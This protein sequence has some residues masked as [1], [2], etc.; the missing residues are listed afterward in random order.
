M[1]CETLSF[2]EVGQ[3]SVA[4]LLTRYRVDLL[5]AVRPWQLGEIGE[6]V[7]RLR[8]AGVFVALW[9]MLADDHGRWASVQSCVRFVALVDQVLDRA[10]FADELVLDLEP[11]LGRMHGWKAGRPTFR[12]TPSPGA[13]TAAR[14]TYVA[15]VT[16]WRAERRVTTAVVPLLV[17]ERGQWLQR[18]LGTPVTDLPVERHS[19]MAY[20]SLFE[21]WS[22]GLVDRRRAESLLVACARLA[23]RRFGT[24]AALSLGTVG[25]G[26]FGDEPSYRDVAELAHDVALARAA[27]ID[28]LS[29]FEL[30][31]I[32]R[33]GPA[34]AWLEA[35]G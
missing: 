31:G 11:P 33:R 4:A 7:Q 14:S 10:R 17:A 34:E 16:R 6:L 24:Q 15:A 18:L 3:P 20:T 1:W 9:P 19:V 35:M 28:E 8:G 32:L 23:R 2:D 5:L 26:V 12:N 13:Y 25:T 29:V 27:D 22:R 30:G 21:G